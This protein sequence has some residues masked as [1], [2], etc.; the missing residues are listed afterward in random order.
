MGTS[1]LTK[2]RIKEL[3]QAIEDDNRSLVSQVIAEQPDA[4]ETLGIG[5]QT[6]EGKTPLMYALQCGRP[7][8]AALL[9][10][11]HANVQATMTA[12]WRWPVL[13]FA[14]RAAVSGV[15]KPEDADILRRMLALGADPN[16]T[17]A[18]G[19]TALDR[20]LGD[21][22]SVSDHWTIIQV[23]LDAGAD[24]ENVGPAKMTTR[25]LVRTNPQSFSARVQSLFGHV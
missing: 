23:L 18:F 22:D 10:D 4:L 21:Y 2:Q 6:F 15:G 12:S 20:A 9:L 16:A 1:K 24:V 5:K 11:H 17:D 3:F 13:H 19:N 25:E 7:G 14:V 8:I